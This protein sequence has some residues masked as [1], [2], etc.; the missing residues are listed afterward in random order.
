MKKLLVLVAV[1]AFV[2]AAQAYVVDNG[3]FEGGTYTQTMWWGGDPTY[4]VP[5][6]WATWTANNLDNMA[7]VAG[8]GSANAL[9]M[10]VLPGNA[11]GGYCQ[12]WN[13]TNTAIGL[14]TT[15][16]TLIVDAKNLTVGAE[17]SGN[18]LGA[19]LTG[20]FASSEVKFVGV[21]GEWGTYSITWAI[22]AT[23]TSVDVNFAVSDDGAWNPNGPGPAG[24]SY[25][26]D[27]VRLV[28]E[29]MTMVLLGLG[30]LFLRRRSK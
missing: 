13:L 11:N 1:L 19:K 6:G 25:A 3:D 10:T 16:V 22:P 17:A 23:T 21:N 7:L 28:P 26:I 9:A 4:Q 30:G 12:M 14:G 18:F 5:T 29:P 24:C 15:S 20:G 27:N 2:G 8:N